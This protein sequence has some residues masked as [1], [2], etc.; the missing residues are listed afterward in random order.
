MARNYKA[1]LHIAKKELGLDDETYREILFDLTR[2]RSSKDMTATELQI[3]L[4]YFQ[5]KGF[6]PKWSKKSRR[7]KKLPY[8]DLGWRADFAAPRQLRM[9]EAIW[10]EAARTPTDAA[11]RKFL[12]N[13]FKIFNP[14]WIRADLVTPIKAALMRMKK[15]KIGTEAQ[16][17][18]VEEA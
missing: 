15:E 2:K 6:K 18:K 14:R 4:A 12:E 8:E 5:E 7:E 3:V 17:H 1:L 13:R 10:R 9:L 11:Y 16:R